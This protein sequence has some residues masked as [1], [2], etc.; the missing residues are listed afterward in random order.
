MSTK[1]G[2]WIGSGDLDPERAEGFV[3]V[4]IEKR[5]NR[6]YIGKKNFRGQGRLN[7]GQPSNWRTY[8]SSSRYLN[9][10][11]K[12]Q[13][14]DAFRFIILEQYY[15]R[16][17]LSFAETWSQVVCETPSRNEEFMNRYIDKVTWKVTEPVTA[18][19]KKKLKYY[20]TQYKHRKTR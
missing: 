5:T 19:H 12:E 16:G 14:R 1:Y 9:E 11:I 10:I 15:T 18:R 2:I 17:G 13:G 7:R 20:L 4:I 6:K 8:T 3:Y